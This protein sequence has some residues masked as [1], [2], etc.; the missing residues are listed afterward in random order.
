MPG[1][2]AGISVTVGVVALLVAGLLHF[3]GGRVWPRITVLLIVIGMMSIVGTPVGQL[4][5]R[6]AGTA[7]GWLSGVL[8]SWLGAAVSGLT[9]ITVAIILGLDVWKKH[10]G[11]RTLGCAAALPV[12]GATIPGP[13]GAVVMGVC[14]A[15]AGVVGGG[16]QWM[17]GG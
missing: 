4:L 17:F 3:V 8:T 10:I 5:R 11:T 12:A 6:W 13:A 2:E 7:D 15:L 9:G 14:G 16:G 1:L